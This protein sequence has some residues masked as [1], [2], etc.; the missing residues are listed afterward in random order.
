MALASQ[1]GQAPPSLGAVSGAVAKG[2]LG[3]G[4]APVPTAVRQGLARGRDPLAV[5][6]GHRWP[7]LPDGIDQAAAETAAASRAAAVAAA[8]PLGAGGGGVA[9]AADA[10]PRAAVATGPVAAGAIATG[11]TAR[12]S[13]S[14][15]VDADDVGRT[16]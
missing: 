13:A 7:R 10:A 11:V 16:P 14:A 12:C 9:A 1:R 8:S 6:K 3:H 15:V 5:P 2:P 4:T